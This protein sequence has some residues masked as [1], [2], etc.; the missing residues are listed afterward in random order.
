MEDMELRR[1]R[2]FMAVA[3]ELHFGRA[4]ARL[5]IAQPPLSA[6]IQQLERELGVQLFDRTNR[7]V[8][9][10]KEGEVFLGEAVVLLEQYERAVQAVHQASSGLLGRIVVA[11]V[12]SAFDEILPTVIPR[13]RAGH[14]D[15]VLSLREA[16]T[17]EALAALARGSLDVAFVRLERGDD[18]IAVRPL[19]REKFAVAVPARH[20]LAG[21]AEVGLGDLATEAF[22]MPLRSVASSYF[23]QL[24]DAC[25]RAG[26]NPR[27]AHQ[28]NSIQSQ[29]G[30]VACGL[31]VALVPRTEHLLQRSNVVFLPL[32]EDIAVTEVSL[33][34]SQL[35]Q[36]RVVQRFL[37]VVDEL[38]PAG[39]EQDPQTFRTALP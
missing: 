12:A 21:Q 26:F 16:D 19:R 11:G 1:I 35:R 27:I 18:E 6:Q 25:R 29:V 4:A 32:K 34:W 8:R 3:E 36:P 9:L 39:T 37:D 13:F 38:Y 30:F 14:P 5:H 2:Y 24:L 31:G 17:A 23:D 28:S 33:A 10:T 20:P 7:R 22:V 15:V